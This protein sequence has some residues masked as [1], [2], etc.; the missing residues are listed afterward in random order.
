MAVVPDCAWRLASQMEKMM[1]SKFLAAVLVSA[2]LAPGLV[3]AQV[4][5]DTR[6]TFE[7]QKVFADGNS[8]AEVTVSIDCNTGTILD[9]DKDLAHGESVEF[10]VTNFT[11]GT[12]NCTITEDDGPDGYSALYNYPAETPCEYE[13][14]TNGAA[15][16]CVITNEPDAV[17]LEINKTWEIAGDNNDVDLDFRLYVYCSN[18]FDP[19][20]KQVV[21][22]EVY[23][24][25]DSGEGPGSS[26][27]TFLIWPGY[28]AASCYVN[29]SVY[30]SAIEVDNNCYNVALS[31]AQG[32]SCEITNTVFF[33]GIPTLSQYGMAIMALLML[34][35]GLVGFRR[36]A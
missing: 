32:A 25:S 21:A 16:L 27:H 7:V 33:E 11:D 30:D 3:L 5:G 28:P 12:L 26:T 31:A 9:Q 22:G 24:G 20:T 15:E 6:A 36:F 10:V 19:G 13:A 4:Q 18:T 8:D 23:I 35:A 29:E 14:V 17:E 34:C 2:I 1:Q